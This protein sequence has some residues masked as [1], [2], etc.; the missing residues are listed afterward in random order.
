MV[1]VRATEVP[2]DLVG[3]GEIFFKGFGE[4]EFADDDVGDGGEEDFG[5]MREEAA[6]RDGGAVEPGSTGVCSRTD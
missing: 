3:R 2:Q 4:T 6:D 5:D 1:V